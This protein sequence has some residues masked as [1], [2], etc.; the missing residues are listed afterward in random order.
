MS[1]LEGVND[2]VSSILHLGGASAVILATPRLLQTVGHGWELRLGALVQTACV[3]FLLLASGAYHLSA[4][5]FGEPHGLTDVLVRV[6]HAGVWLIFAGF[7]VLPHLILERGA[8]RWAP[9]AVVWA[10][11]LFG[12]ATKM[13]YYAEQSPVEI[14][15]PHAL[16]SMVGILSTCRFAYRHGVRKTSALFAFWAAFTGAAFCYVFHAPNLIP[17]VFGYH[18]VWHVGILLGVYA[19]WRFVTGLGDD[20]AEAF[21]A[22]QVGLLELLGLD[23]P[24]R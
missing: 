22:N 12:V 13:L 11:A 2:L 17:G 20:A 24:D 5:M 23:V 18:E 10:V 1:R 6:D 4:H 9:L 8:W 7:F 3:A 16:A 15:V 21:P 19:H 14:V